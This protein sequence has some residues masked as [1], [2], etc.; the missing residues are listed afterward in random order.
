MYSW[1]K[2][3]VCILLEYFHA[4]F[5]MSNTPG[6]STSRI[7]R[8]ISQIRKGVS[9]T[10]PVDFWQNYLPNA[11]DGGSKVRDWG[12]IQFIYLPLIIIEEMPPGMYPMLLMIS[13][14]YPL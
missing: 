12:G 10:H 4:L 3:T 5:V 1:C 6:T 9:L 7:L 2:W 11:M 13:V 8:V 14:R